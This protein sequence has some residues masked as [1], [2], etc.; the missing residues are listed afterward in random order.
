MYSIIS[1][2]VS[3]ISTLIAAINLIWDIHKSKE[4]SA[5]DKTFV[6]NFN[7]I[8][9]HQNDNDKSS[10]RL[11][12]CTCSIGVI[13]IS[14]G[15]FLW[16]EP[17]FF[18]I[19]LLQAILY[20]VSNIKSCNKDYIKLKYI[21][22]S[23]LFF[24]SICTLIFINFDKNILYFSKLCIAA[25]SSIWYMLFDFYFFKVFISKYSKSSK[26]KYVKNNVN[27]ELVISIFITL[28][29][30]IFSIYQ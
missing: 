13:A 26:N 6:L 22:I 4:K 7:I 25:I 19:L 8:N 1:L 14:Y 24:A 16:N 20:T 2:T 10:L 12:N 27:N 15:V 9:T 30:F 29:T 5:D 11:E 3:I 18:I 17:V 21:L 23:L 28:I